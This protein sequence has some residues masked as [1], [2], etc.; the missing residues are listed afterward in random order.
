MTGLHSCINLMFTL[1]ILGG[2]CY[3][4]CQV[5]SCETLNHLERDLNIFY[6]CSTYCITFWYFIYVVMAT[7]SMVTDISIEVY[8][9]KIFIYRRSETILADYTN[10][11]S[12]LPKGDPV[13]TMCAQSD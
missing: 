9:A 13:K 6:S 10:F 7:I 8:I 3:P 2:C 4:L 11:P 12:P 5:E 1:L